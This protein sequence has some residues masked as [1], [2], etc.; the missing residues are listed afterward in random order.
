MIKIFKEN[1]Y[2]DWVSYAPRPDNFDF[3]HQRSCGITS[4]PGYFLTPSELEQFAR[5]CFEAA[6]ENTRIRGYT[7]P[8]FKDFATFWAERKEKVGE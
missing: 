1:K 5:E 3:E 7:E 4:T 8:E 2:N 6:R